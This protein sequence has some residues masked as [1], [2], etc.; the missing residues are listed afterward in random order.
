MFNYLGS[1]ARLTIATFSAD[2]AFAGGRMINFGSATLTNAIL[3]GNTPDQIY[4]SGP[5]T[6][7]SRGAR[8][9]MTQK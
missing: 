1:S 5:V 3:W 6:S 9:V 4:D 8:R 7:Y 2:S